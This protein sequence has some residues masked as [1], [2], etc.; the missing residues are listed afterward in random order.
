M[1]KTGNHGIIIPRNRELLHKLYW[2]D[3]LTLTMIANI[4][5]VNHK[6]VLSVFRK[7]EIPTRAKGI[8]RHSKCLD[9]GGRII[10]IK[11]PLTKNG[12]GTRC[13]KCRRAHYAALARNYIK[14]PRVKEKRKRYMDSWKLTGNRNPKGESQWINKAKHLLRTNRRL[15]KNPGA[16]QS[17][18]KEFAQA[19]T[20]QT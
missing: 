9:C 15:L 2:K 3:D 10:K 7:L 14:L 19:Q 5:C 8:S 6:S 20:S 4:F 17:L 12:Y 18:I 13:Q 1:A 11:H 16:R